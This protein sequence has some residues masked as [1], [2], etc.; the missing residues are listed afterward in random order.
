MGLGVHDKLDVWG[1]TN[2]TGGKLD[3]VL[4]SG[5]TPKIGDQF[6]II[7]GGNGPVNIEFESVTDGYTVYANGN[8]VILEVVP[9]PATLSLLALGGLR[10]VSR[11]QNY[12][13]I[14]P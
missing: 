12:P 7:G 2:I 5:Y 4:D 1:R 11:R 8:D 10:L 6:T 9:E 3:I 13:G 14:K